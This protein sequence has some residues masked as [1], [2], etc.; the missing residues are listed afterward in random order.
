ALD[1]AVELGARVINIS[2]GERIASRQAIHPQLASAVDRCVAQG[3][4]VIAAAGNDGCDCQQAPA[5]LPGVLPVGAE[6]AHGRPVAFSNWGA[7]YRQRGLLARGLDLVGAAAAGGTARR[8][9]TS[10][11]TALVSGTAALLASYLVQREA[12]VDGD[13]VRRILIET[14]RPCP[15]AGSACDRFLAGSLDVEAAFERLRSEVES[16]PVLAVAEAPPPAP[17]TP[18]EPMEEVA[19]NPRQEPLQDA[20]QEAAPETHSSLPAAAQAPDET[21]SEAG[22]SPGIEP[23]AVDSDPIGERTAPPLSTAVL[24]SD[25]VTTGTGVAPAG[26]EPLAY[27]VGHLDIGFVSPARRDS[28]EQSMGGVSPNDLRQLLAHLDKAPWE[29]EAVVWLLCI[30]GAP[31]YV[32]HPG[33]AFA[34]QSYG[35]LRA[36]LQE[37]IDGKAERVAVPGR[38]YGSVQL[39]DYGTLPL[40]WPDPRGLAAWTTQALVDA[41]AGPV[42]KGKKDAEDHEHAVAGVRNFLERV[43]YELRNPGTGPHDRSLNFAATN[44]FQA[45]DVLQDAARAKLE[46]DTIEA[47]PSPVAR[48]GS[49]TWDVKLVFFD[50]KHRLETAR[51]I[52][53]FTVD[54]SDVIP[55]TVGPVR[56][57]AIY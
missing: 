48:P 11:A 49:D 42:P 41:V 29:A 24:E 16:R 32:V 17:N 8:D 22:A 6:D 18:H 25:T 27:V 54:V 56:S 28:L 46:L 31:I 12:A 1:R 21:P 23:L 7:P 38:V 52:Y 13:R 57:W 44:A 36:M 20:A 50:P 33:G 35:R 19:M 26:A 47:E 37:Q 53:R 4:L 43:Y 15:E 3:V 30:E 55:V 40:L 2:G 51:R 39:P 45:Y 10:F 9:G 34:E 5:A 14:A